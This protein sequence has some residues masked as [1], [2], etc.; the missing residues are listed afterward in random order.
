MDVNF[1]HRWQRCR[2]TFMHLVSSRG[3]KLVCGGSRGLLRP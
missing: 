2:V 3:W 1:I